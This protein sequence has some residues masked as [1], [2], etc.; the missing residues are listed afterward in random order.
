MAEPSPGKFSFGKKIEIKEQDRVT[1]PVILGLKPPV[2]LGIL[3][4]AAF[5]LVIFL[6]LVYPGIS[7]PGSIG[8]FISEPSGAAVRIDDIT[9]GF[10]PCS[11]FM[12]KGSHTI[13]FVLPGFKPDKQELDVKG[14]IFA[15]LFFPSK[16]TVSGDLFC[17]DPA[18]ALSRSAIEFMYWAAAGEPTIGFQNPLCLSEGVYRAGRAARSPAIRKTMQDILDSSLRYAITGTSIRDLLRSQFLLDNSGLSPSALTA[19]T[20]LQKIAVSLESSGASSQWLADMLGRAD[21]EKL[22]KSEWYRKNT[23]VQSGVG[24]V[25]LSFSVPS[26]LKLGGVSFISVN[27]GYLEKYGL[28]E[29][30]PPMLA[31]LSPVS[32]ESWELF[33]KE[34]PGWDISNKDDLIS[35]GLIGEDYLTEI[36]NPVF[37]GTAAPGISWYAAKA[38]CGWLTT[39]LPASL[40][41]WEITIP[42][43]NQWEYAVQKAALDTGLLWEWCRDPYAP[44]DFF[45][46]SSAALELLEQ[47]AKHSDVF[48]LERTVK[49]GSWINVSSMQD[50]KSRGSL[51]PQTS[52]PF[53]GFR[54]VIIPKQVE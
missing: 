50:I 47:A 40:A 10:T 46:V 38:Y 49:G 30:I 31:A 33:T 37:S 34:N 2:Y 16:I 39:K 6:A 41:G 20:S 32:R 48:P 7:K 14:R 21:A 52:S 26:S 8:I 29:V 9:L 44:L 24:S 18:L 1:L 51:P 15:S 12:P 17:A 3:Y 4:G 27:S 45:P 22:V 5:L 53:A 23:V 35:R 13:E 28:K 36:D 42:S 43:E 19:L 11:I 54:P 25:E